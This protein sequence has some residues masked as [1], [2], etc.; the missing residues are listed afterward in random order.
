MDVASLRV[1]DLF[2]VVLAAIPGAVAGGRIGYAFL[3]LDSIWPTPARWSTRRRGASSSGLP[4]S[5]AR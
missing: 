4:L 1:D 5:A 3:H 2:F